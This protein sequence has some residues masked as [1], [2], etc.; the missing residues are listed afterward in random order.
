MQWRHVA[1]AL[2]VCVNIQE[3]VAVHQAITHLLASVDALL[4]LCNTNFVDALSLQ[5]IPQISVSFVCAGSY[6]LPA[7]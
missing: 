6:S 4:N 7:T 5:H 3:K 2:S 1:Q